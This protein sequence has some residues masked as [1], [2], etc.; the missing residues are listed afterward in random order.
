MTKQITKLSG[1]SQVLFKY[2]LM[3]TP[4]YFFQVEMKLITMLTQA[5][6]YIKLKV[7]NGLF[8]QTLMEQLLKT[9]FGLKDVKQITQEEEKQM[10]L[11]TGVFLI[12][13]LQTEIIIMHF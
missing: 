2:L 1:N 12:T 5:L 6:N 4:L 10:A 11:L 13:L 8:L 9:L 3:D 7:M